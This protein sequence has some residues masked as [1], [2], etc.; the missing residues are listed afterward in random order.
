MDVRPPSLSFLKTVK[1]W[2]GAKLPTIL[3][4]T[5]LVAAIVAAAA[6]VKWT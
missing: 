3:A 6:D 2:L 1:T 5:S 4:L